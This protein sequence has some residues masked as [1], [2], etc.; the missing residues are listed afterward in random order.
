[1]SDLVTK[2]ENAEQT[3]R[4]YTKKER[5][6]YLTGL[7]GQNMVYNIV[8]G[9]FSYFAQF[10]LAIPAVVVS[11]IL[12][13][14]RIWD[15]FNDPMM[16]TIVDKT[17]TKW[18]KC[19]PYLLFTPPIIMVI[20]ILCFVSWGAYQGT[21]NDL[22][23][24]HNLLVVLWAGVMY[25]LWGMAYT[26]GDIPLWGVTAL[27]TESADDR[28][29]LISQ[30]RIWAGIGAGLVMLA[31]QPLSFAVKDIVFEFKAG[32]S[33]A[34][35]Q[36]TGTMT[37][38]QAIL[39]NECEQMGFFIVAAVLSVIA[40]VLFQMAGIGVREKI[41][42]S[43][44]SYTLKKN[45]TLM[46]T[47]KPFRQVLLSGILGSPKMLVAN[48]AM[49][50]I[51]YYFASKDA[52]KA[53]LYM[54]ILG[55]AVFGGQFVIQAMTPSL[56]KKY[57]KKDLYNWGNLISTVPFALVFV[58]YWFAP[59]HD[60][61]GWGYIALMFVLF[62]ICG[63]GI[64]LTYVLQSLMIADAVDY[65]EYHN[66]VRTDGAF[67]AGQTFLA[68]LTSAITTII[69][70]LAYAA[71][72]F[73]DAKVEEINAFVAAGGIPRTEPAYSSFMTVLFFIVSIPAAIGCILAVL[74]TWN[75]AQPDTMH[76]KI[77]AE[78]IERRKADRAQG[79]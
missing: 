10:T 16:G 46:W 54:I 73:S 31:I 39:E 20:T 7:F 6:M 19:R 53:L 64:G 47:N 11:A 45:F 70:G 34:H 37:A 8:N 71:V 12:A 76:E 50:L 67:F 52:T 2:L 36:E 14:A 72:G 22:F 59:N 17:R 60:V 68:K 49:P 44:Q 13:I 61:T 63:A 62:L 30:A 3:L 4:T 48:A 55:G 24:S 51:N 29:R 35:L 79:E 56:V 65:E 27:M 1:M 18:G 32:V 23:T 75:Y 78:L 43:K 5:N 26:A 42:P 58:I 38:K 28:S 33:L 69:S 25:I 74:P 77:L 41:P 57:E 66:G 21:T 40:Y 15:A 9:A